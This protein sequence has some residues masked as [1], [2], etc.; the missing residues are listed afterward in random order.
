MGRF[1][2]EEFILVLQNSNLEQSVHVAER[3]R[4]AIEEIEL[5]SDDGRQI[6]VTAS[7][8]I[9]ISSPELRPQ[10][11]LSHADQALYAAKAGGRNRVKS[12]QP[13]QILPDAI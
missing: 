13:Q 5:F 2:G 4:K 7:F 6:Y 8:G 9:A 11:L 12:Y 3:C 1:G 10:Q